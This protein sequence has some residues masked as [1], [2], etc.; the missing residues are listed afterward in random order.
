MSRLDW[1]RAKQS[2][3]I[4]SKFGSGVVMP[5][6][7]RT[8]IVHEDTSLARRANQEMRRWL[9]SLPPGQRNAVRFACPMPVSIAGRD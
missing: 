5:N 6:G 1:R 9:R 8:A 4:E 3:P 7:E 2:R